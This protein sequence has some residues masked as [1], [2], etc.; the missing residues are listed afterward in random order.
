MSIQYSFSETQPL[1]FTPYPSVTGVVDKCNSNRK[2]L[3]L[4]Q[5]SLCWCPFRH[6]NRIHRSWCT[7]SKRMVSWSTKDTVLI[8]WMSYKNFFISP[9]RSTRSQMGSMGVWQI[10]EHGTE[11]LANLSEGFVIC[12]IFVLPYLWCSILIGF[13]ISLVWFRNR[14]GRQKGDRVVLKGSFFFPKC[15][16]IFW[17]QLFKLDSPNRWINPSPV[18]GAIGFPNTYPL[19][20]EYL[21]DS[22]IQ[23]FNNLGLTF[24]SLYIP[25]FDPSSINFVS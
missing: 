22:A 11:W 5:F 13:V 2:Q 4:V 16:F 14:I 1:I 17:S 23:V 6:K 18:D 24:S 8:W 20:S 9:T 25:S 21:V 7:T 19:D 15:H 3:K 10:M 12:G